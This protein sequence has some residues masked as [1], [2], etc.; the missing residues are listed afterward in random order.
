MN[1]PKRSGGSHDGERTHGVGS[2]DGDS[3]QTNPFSRL[4]SVSAGGSVAA[5][6]SRDERLGRAKPLFRDREP[7][8]APSFDAEEDDAEM[9]DD[10]A[11]PFDRRESTSADGQPFPAADDDD[12]SEDEERGRPSDSFDRG[13]SV[14]DDSPE[15][16]NDGRKPFKSLRE[17][18]STVESS[19]P[20]DTGV[21]NRRPK[22]CVSF[23]SADDFDD[24]DKQSNPFSAGASGS[25]VDAEDIGGRFSRRDLASSG[26]S[27]AADDSEEINSKQDNLFNRVRSV[28]AS[29]S[30]S[31]RNFVGKPR[32]KREKRSSSFS[33]PKSSSL[34]G[35]S[36]AGSNADIGEG[37]KQAKPLFRRLST[38]QD[39]SCRSS[40]PGNSLASFT[41]RD[42]SERSA[43][44]VNPFSL[45]KHD[46]TS[47][48]EGRARPYCVLDKY[49]IDLGDEEVCTIGDKL[50]SNCGGND[51]DETGGEETRSSRKE[52]KNKHCKATIMV[53]IVWS[54]TVTL[55]SIALGMDW[56]NIG[57]S[58]DEEDL[59]TLCGENGLDFP[60]DEMSVPPTHQP[61][62]SGATVRLNTIDPPPANLSK[63]CAPS[64]RLRHGSHHNG[65]LAGSLVEDCMK[66][67][68]PA[69][70]CLANNSE[71]QEGLLS[72]IGLDGVDVNQALA[73]TSTVKDCYRGD[74]IP[75]CEAYS[76]WCATLY[77]LDL[78]LEES[79][80]AHFF[81]T[82]H[83]SQE[84]EEDMVTATTRASNL[85]PCA[86]LC[87][88][89]GCCY[90]NRHEFTHVMRKRVRQHKHNGDDGKTNF[91][92]EPWKRVEEEE[93]QHFNQQDPLN[94]QVCDAY[95]PFCSHLKHKLTLTLAFPTATKPSDA[96]TQIPSTSFHPS[97]Q[98]PW[99]KIPSISLDP[100]P[101]PSW[102]KIPSISLDASL[103]PSQADD[104]PIP[105]S[106]SLTFTVPS[107]FK[108][109]PMPTLHPHVRPPIDLI[110]SKEDNSLSSTPDS[111]SSSSSTVSPS[112]QPLTTNSPSVATATDQTAATL[113][114]TLT[115]W[116]ISSVNVPSQHPSS[117]VI[118]SADT[119]PDIP[120]V[121]SEQPPLPPSSNAVNP[122]LERT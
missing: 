5:E 6:E 63:V 70:C 27:I 10:Q 17:T 121:P 45:R 95:S 32:G 34:H 117:S 53:C 81:G 43:V 120:V 39:D 28:R 24:L 11:N 78:V 76:E 74:D 97:S 83:R 31:P 14:G 71:A 79:L 35:S 22:D 118:L 41:V 19:V 9:S 109:S 91:Q 99:S 92:T 122:S 94:T 69:I 13:E 86:E 85:A 16:M 106:I 75:I 50:D 47:N 84:N 40:G 108:P 29:R 58:P 68:Q 113:L 102:S 48:G 105:G 8:G 72:M 119:A 89:L 56:F 115:P 66:A 54:T 38:I 37:A 96:A 23:T 57:I 60:V 107:T 110:P 3:R 103:L 90:E 55:I 61:S 67:C 77:S 51:D 25:A 46:D 104:I 26:G 1:R 7:P 33:T 18:T 87:R 116:S 93:C 80:P 62:S 65:T 42:S 36:T 2:D 101:Q 64:I 88:P 73:Y 20:D 44:Q 82:C 100:S 15:A 114:V 21:I 30:I 112:L 12:A 49:N 4:G 59:C 111:S 52:V 98:P